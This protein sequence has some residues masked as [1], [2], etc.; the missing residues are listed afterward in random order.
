MNL[1][2]STSCESLSVLTFS[3]GEN[4][5]KKEKKKQIQEKKEKKKNTRKISKQQDRKFQM[6]LNFIIIHHQS[7][8]TSSWQEQHR[9][10]TFHMA[11]GSYRR[12]RM[13]KNYRTSMIRQHWTPSTSQSPHCLLLSLHPAARIHCWIDEATLPQH[14]C[15]LGTPLPT[16]VTWAK[17]FKLPQQWRSQI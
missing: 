6:D 4:W 13:P 15:H 2:S 8:S 1:L 7:S 14:Y 10:P 12:Q 9:K 11:A 3:L 17:M 16:T 5:E